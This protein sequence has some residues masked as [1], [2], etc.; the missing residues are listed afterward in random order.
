MP[1]PLSRANPTDS[2]RM[3]KAVWWHWPQEQPKTQMAARNHS[4]SVSLS[5]EL[6]GEKGLHVLPATSLAMED[7]DESHRG[8]AVKSH[9]ASGVGTLVIKCPFLGKNNTHPENNGSAS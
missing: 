7:R 4:V 1:R 2:H 9:S 3:P 8:T 6:P 5:I